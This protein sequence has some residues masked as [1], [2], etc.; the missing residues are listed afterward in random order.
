MLP[1]DTTPKVSWVILPMAPT[2]VIPVSPATRAATTARTK[3]SST[4]NTASPTPISNSVTCAT[5]ASTSAAPNPAIKAARGIVRGSSDAAVA[6]RFTTKRP[7]AKAKAVSGTFN[8][9]SSVKT[10]IAI[11]KM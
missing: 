8:R 10:R 1:G 9:S 2:G 7:N 5:L 3:L 4:A 11:A 6:L